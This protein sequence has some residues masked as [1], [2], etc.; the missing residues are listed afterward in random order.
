MSRWLLHLQSIPMLLE[1]LTYRWSVGS[2]WEING[3]P[4][5]PPQSLRGIIFCRD[6]SAFVVECSLLPFTSSQ[7]VAQAHAVGHLDHQVLSPSTTTRRHSLGG[8]CEGGGYPNISYSKCQISALVFPL[9]ECLIA[10]S[11]FFKVGTVHTLLL[12]SLPV[13]Y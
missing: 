13:R 4:A 9:I 3:S 5:V 12:I 1:S 8:G 10:C 11:Y 6:R 2:S 7:W